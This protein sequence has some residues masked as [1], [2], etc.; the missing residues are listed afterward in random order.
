MNPIDIIESRKI[1]MGITSE[2]LCR[3]TDGFVS[4]VSYSNYLHRK[5]PP[6]YEAIMRL[7]DVVGLRAYFVDKDSLRPENIWNWGIMD[8]YCLLKKDDVVSIW[9]D[10]SGD[11]Y[12]DFGVLRAGLF[13]IWFYRENKRHP[14]RLVGEDFYGESWD[15]LGDRLRDLG[16]LSSDKP[17]SVGVEYFGRIS[18]AVNEYLTT[19]NLICEIDWISE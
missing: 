15:G 12:G 18:D 5:T 19:A 4:S 14:G 1:R 2:E 8:M 9:K 11:E 10:L 7:G 6:S 17:S 16:I 3:R 13:Y